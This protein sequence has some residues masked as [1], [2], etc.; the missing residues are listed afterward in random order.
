[1]TRRLRLSRDHDELLDGAKGVATIADL[2]AFAVS[3]VAFFGEDASTT[4]AAARV[5]DR[6][7][8]STG[9]G[10]ASGNEVS[11][12]RERAPVGQD[13]RQSVERSTRGLVREAKRTQALYRAAARQCERCSRDLPISA[14]CRVQKYFESRSTSSDCSCVAAARKSWPAPAYEHENRTS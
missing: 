12:R 3:I 6:S 8:R 4:G 1:M 11:V 10:S 7:V 14:R 13:Y 2:E 9:G 5:R